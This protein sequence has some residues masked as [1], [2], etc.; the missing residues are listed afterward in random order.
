MKRKYVI[1]SAAAAL[2]LVAS[3]T[4]YAARHGG[5]AMMKGHIVGFIEDSLQKNPLSD[6]QKQ[7]V[8]AVVDKT[9]TQM[10]DA[11]AE[12]K[13]AMDQAL[14]LFQADTLDTAALQKLHT[15]RMERMSATVLPALSEVH[16]I[17]SPAQRAEL[18]QAIREH[19][20][21]GEGHG[22]WGP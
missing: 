17:L 5:G 20:A 3:G 13:G 19:H 14:S 8:E 15:D 7:A 6:Q 10:K 21:K 16:D 2:L 9:F 12:H 18:V 11:R 1:V 22:F 4:V